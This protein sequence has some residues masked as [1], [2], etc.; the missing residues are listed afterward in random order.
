MQFAAEVKELLG[1]ARKLSVEQLMKLTGISRPLAELNHRRYQDILAG[2]SERH[3][4]LF[5]FQGDTYQGLQAGQYNPADV[6]RAQQR[7]RII[8]GLYGLLRPLDAMW[9]YRLEMVT[10]LS[11][12]AGNNLYKF[13]GN[14]LS[15][16]LAQEM[17]EAGVKT[18]VNLASP[19]YAK[20]LAPQK[21]PLQVI[22]PKFMDYSGDAFK[23][24]G[25]FAKKARGMMASYIIEHQLEQPADLAGFR[26]DGYSYDA[27]AST[28]T[29]PVFC[30]KK[31]S[32]A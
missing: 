1:E 10:S 18:L 7:L 11:N 9:P 13:W 28:P 25:F 29:E 4:A 3:T 17:E 24:I 27:K 20:V 23:V 26:I 2:D 12:R 15:E 16:H 14:K 6:R 8:S 30:R 22:T 21:F 32:A 5:L 31:L 19:A